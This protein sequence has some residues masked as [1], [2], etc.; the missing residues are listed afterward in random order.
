MKSSL[1]ASL[2]S[3]A[4]VAVAGVMLA[5]PGFVRAQIAYDDAGNYLV[6]AN[7]TNGANGGF[8]FEPWVIATNGPDFT[9]TYIQSANSP[10][11]VIASVTNILTTNYTSVWGLFANGNDAINETVAYRGFSNSLGTNT[12][13]LQWGSR[14]AGSTTVSNIGAVHGWCG[15]ALRT[16]N[17]TNGTGD[18]DSATG[19][20]LY[21]YFKDGNAP[22]TLYFW[23]GN[24][25]QSI[26]NTSFSDLGRQNITNAIAAEITP[27]ADGS[28]YHMVLKDSVQNRTIFTTNG[29]FI[30]G[31]TTVDSVALFCQ[32]TTG[33]QIYNRMQIVSPTNIPPTI[34]N[35]E[36]PDGTLYTNAATTSLSFEVDSFNSTVSSNA[37]SVYLNGALQSGLTFNSAVPTNQLQVACGGTTLSPD[38]FYNFTIVVQDANGNVVSN[39]YTFN[40]FLPTDIYIDAYDYNYNEGQF[41][42]SN[43]PTNG[44]ANLLG[45]NFIDYQIADLS[46]SN[47]TAGYRPGDLVETLSLAADATGDP[48]DHA[49]LRA[50]SFTA[51]NI[52][53]TD[54]GNWENY[55]RVYPVANYNIY[56]RAASA[57][58]GQFEVEK[59]ANATATTTNQPLIALGRVNVPNTSGSKV[60]TGQLTPVIDFFGN[61]VVMP[62]SGTTTLRE[63]ALASRV[64]NLEYF[65][66]VA[67]PAAGTLRPYIATG[68]PA[69]N[70]TG[71]LLNTPITASIAHRQTTVMTNTIQLILNNTN[72][73]SRLVMSSNA[74]G[75][76]VTWTPTNNWPA[77]FTNSVVLIFTDS[78]GVSI[79]NS[80][81]FITGTTG[82]ILGNGVWSGGGGTNDLFWADGV[83]WTGGTPGP[84]SSATFATPGATNAL[85]TNNIVSTNVTIAQ[86]N[87]AT[88][89]AGFHTTLI[90]NGVTLTVSNGTTSTTAAFQVGGIPNG[91]N[92]FNGFVTNTITGLGGTLLITGN[93]PRA[94]G[95]ANALN[96]QV[97]QCANPPAPYQTTLDMSGLG[98]LTAVVGKF[99]LAQGGSGTFQT[100]VSALVYLARTNSITLLRSGNAGQFEVG[101]SSGGG[102]TLPGSALYLGITNAFFVDTA[103]F[104]KQKA[105]NNL[106]AFN[107]A[108]TNGLTPVAYLRGTNGFPTNRLNLWTVGDADTDTVVPIKSQALTDFSGGRLDALIGQM[109]LGRNSTSASDTGFAQGTFTFTAGTLDVT[110]LQIGVQRAAS[111]APA[112]GTMNVIGTATLSSANIIIAQT[113]SGANASLVTGN[114]N[115]TNGTVR[116]N[117]TAGGGN[118]TVNLISGT[119]AVSNNV[120]TPAAPLQT[121]NLASASLHLKA[122]G[123]ST[124][125]NIVATTV[126]TSGTTTITID[127][128]T[129]VSGPVTIHLLGYTGA[130]PFAS[131]A[132]APV[133]AAYTGS[134]VD[135]PGSVDLSINTNAFVPPPP[136]P[137][138]QKIVVSGGQVIIN[139]T[140]N[141]GAGGTY[142]V[143]TS[144]N[145]AVPLSN[146]VVLTN[147][148]FDGNGNFSSTNAAGTNNP[149]FYILR[150]P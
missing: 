101:D 42:N 139:G 63:T 89:S 61:T 138:I 147:S 47:N 74:A 56:A 4:F 3:F 36:P 60:F 93:D 41:L 133:P 132:L 14:G 54:T 142:K 75:V 65:A 115:V 32:E 30:G 116:G 127:S 69:P 40:T 104:G 99:Y 72:V 71:V 24:S 26:P 73:T 125:T 113:A 5:L 123:N 103:R 20:L 98:T 57:S 128:V 134:L 28:S 15:F 66:I 23:D 118:S 77:N 43:T 62:L 94:G 112:T 64:Y 90:S 48:V 16:G 95:G 6:N 148:S 137:T 126:T 7:W 46:G 52:G 119:L 18:F 106:V 130:D 44:Y 143:L 70:S 81:S 80:W 82:G 25:V 17:A 109:V 122:D 11:F 102:I 131:L 8:G 141:N 96:F 86:L 38:T 150:V 100:N 51:Y 53:F 129:N 117:I 105:T 78:G 50:N 13:K 85:V 45:T 21:V 136:P 67:V 2:R 120:G 144:T 97:R 114:L 31:A 49:N 107:P 33:D 76:T 92:T 84:G 19:I 27:G 39:N 87:Y 9:G 29:I 91:D 12:F 37:V 108:F 1:N 88:N 58:G 146:W 83:N 55:T 68:S 79:T 22:S 59:L 10:T 121:L 35:L 135:N 145:I 140:N 34:S 110:N 124:G 149:Q 111:T